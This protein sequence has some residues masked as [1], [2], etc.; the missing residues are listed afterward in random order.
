MSVKI[1]GPGGISQTDGDSRYVNV[2]GDTMTGSLLVDNLVQKDANAAGVALGYYRNGISIGNQSPVLWTDGAPGGAVLT[3]QYGGRKALTEGAA[4]GFVK[5]G[6]ASGGIVGGRIKYTVKATDGTDHQARSGI[7]VFAAVNKG[8]VLTHTISTVAADT[9]VAALSA[10]TLTN[11]IT[12]ALAT[13]ELT[14]SANATS[15]LVQTSLTITYQI[16]LDDA[17]TIT[18]L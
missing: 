1:E 17:A 9:E 14:F 7:V 6:L 11:A 8:D 10:G 12:A 18:G 3:Q 2:T 4:T 5:V 13:N 15:S 16:E